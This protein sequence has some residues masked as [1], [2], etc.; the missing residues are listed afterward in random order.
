MQRSTCRS[1]PSIGAVVCEACYFK[2]LV[3]VIPKRQRKRARP[4]RTKGV[5]ETR[6][7]ISMK[8][9]S[10]IKVSFFFPL[11][12]L[13]FSEK[14]L[15]WF[16]ITAFLSCVL[17]NG[18]QLCWPISCGVLLPRGLM[19]GELSACLYPSL[20]QN[21]DWSSITPRSSHLPRAVDAASGECYRRQALWCWMATFCRLDF[22][23][24]QPL[25]L[26][27]ALLLHCF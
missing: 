19:G 5:K 1:I 22:T 9:T 10:E 14:W 23:C 17:S 15:C 27:D 2:Q 20:I 8:P 11:L 18:A 3:L 4:R 12:F 24:T 21:H 25:F 13:S 16:L 26:K 7:G 6:Q